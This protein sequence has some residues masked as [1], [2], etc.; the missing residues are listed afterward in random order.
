VILHAWSTDGG[1]SF[2]AP[3]RV[4]RLRQDASREGIQTSL[5][6][7]PRG[8]LAVCW[9]QARSPDRYDPRVACTVTAR[10]GGWGPARE[11][12]PG[13]GDK[14]YLTAAVFQGERLWAAAYVSS[15]TSTRLVAVR[16]EG[17]HFGRPVTVN[18]WPVPGDR[19]C[20]PA[21]PDC[22]QGQTFIGDYIGMVAAGRRIVVAYIQ[23]AAGPSE[24]N[25]VLV[26]SFRTK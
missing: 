20:G 22:L 7:S 10:R 9:S 16:G 5:A 19:I 15:A 17:H 24:P 2:S 18:R 12:L 21:P 3:E 8:R 26:S 4:V 6:A 1:V 25:R 14:Q 11:I 13:N 23:P